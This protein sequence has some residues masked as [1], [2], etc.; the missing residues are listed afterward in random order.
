MRKRW[1]GPALVIDAPAKLNL[2]L[3]VLGR[4]PDCYHDLETVMVSIGLYDTLSFEPTVS[5]IALCCNCRDGTLP[6]D[7]SNLVL[8]A[9]HRFAQA[10]KTD[11]GARIRLTKR[12]PMEAG[13]GGGSSDAAATLVGLNTFWNLGWPTERLHEIAAE[14]G[15]DVNFFIDSTALAVCRGRGE[16]IE[17]RPLGQPMWFVIAKP[18]T[19]LST[20]SVF[21]QL[22]LKRCGSSDCEPL[23][24]GC[25]RGDTGRVA[26]LLSNDLETPS[27]ALAA[28]LSE[29]L[30]RFSGLSTAGS[31]MTGSGSACYGIA[32]N[33]EQANRAARVLRQRGSSEVYVVRTAV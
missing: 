11:C 5:G 18:S 20:A 6:A 33:R 17:P 13:M 14:L 4:R 32:Q 25:E 28:E 22:D 31:L 24:H 7:N 12:I 23:L 9:A 1:I 15:S 26:A 19:G 30:E 10:A 8:R 27:R 3:S 2:H 21:R 29:L 16:L